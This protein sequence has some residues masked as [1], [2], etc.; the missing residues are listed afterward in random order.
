[1]EKYREIIIN[2]VET[3]INAIDLIQVENMVQEITKAKRVFCDGLGRSGLAM[4]GF[5]MRIGQMGKESALVGEATAPAFQAGD[6]L[7]ICSASGA[8][9]TLLYHAQKAKK[10]GGKV[11]LITG[12]TN[13][14]LSELADGMIIV[15]APD[16]DQEGASKG[17]IQPM[18][19]LF[20]Q[21]SQLVCDLMAVKL[22]EKLKLT[23]EEM[24]KFHA[25]IE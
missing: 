14:A 18:G 22:M 19:S 5:A 10:L 21:T 11:M 23:S 7:V 20:E 12:K 13:S 9:P 4:R 3:S 16:K 15:Y 8:S 1:M 25:N 17:S 24:R 6:I 2:E